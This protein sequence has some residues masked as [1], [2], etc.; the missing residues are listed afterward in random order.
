MLAWLDTLSKLLLAGG[1]LVLLVSL[2]AALTV[3]SSQSAL[4][5][6]EDVEREGRGFAALATLAAGLAAAGILSGLGGILAF[7]VADW[8]ERHG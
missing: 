3:G 5:G 2:L 8:R 6:F 7:K 4:P 1:G